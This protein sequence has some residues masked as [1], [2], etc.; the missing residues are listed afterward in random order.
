[1]HQPSA[2]SSLSERRHTR[3]LPVI[4]RWLSVLLIGVPSLHQASPALL[5]FSSG[6]SSTNGLVPRVFQGTATSGTTLR[7]P[8]QYPTIQAAI[9]AAATGDL[10]L[11][12]P[13]TYS[14]TPVIANK[15]ISLASE[16]FT[17]GDSSFIDATILQGNGS[18]QGITVQ[19]TAAG[20]SIVGLTIRSG[21]AGVVDG[22]HALG[23]VTVR[24][25]HIIGY[26]DG[27]DFGPPTG[28]TG[29]CTCQFNTIEGSTDDGIDLDGASN[30]LLEGNV[31]RNNHE[32]GIEIRFHDYAGPL[33][34]VIR[35]NRLQGNGQDG[36]QL[37]D[38]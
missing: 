15:G 13:G 1:M 14:E 11:V 30:G 3:I 24:H 21:G 23:S 7:V 18:S 37:I 29:T 31:L 4:F 8:A 2:G 19:A 35:G 6:S 36:I 32:D 27:I 17:T 25:N 22:V 34:I 33:S 10:V 5:P 26:D 28:S 12:A 16:F 9:D 20:T 38:Y